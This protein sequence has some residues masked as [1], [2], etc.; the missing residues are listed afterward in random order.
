MQPKD[1]KE[2]LELWSVLNAVPRLHEIPPTFKDPTNRWVLFVNE[3]FFRGVSMTRLVEKGGID[4]GLALNHLRFVM[5]SWDLKHE[6]KEAAVAFL[7]SQW[8]DFKEEE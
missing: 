6:H 4:R 7:L 3:W 1:A 5:A 8:F 2:L